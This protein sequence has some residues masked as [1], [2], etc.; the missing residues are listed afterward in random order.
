MEISQMRHGRVAIWLISFG[1]SFDCKDIA[2][3]LNN[4]FYIF[5]DLSN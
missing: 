3:N 5:I 4:T 2:L 1:H